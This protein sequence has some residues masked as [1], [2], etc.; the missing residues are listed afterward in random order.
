MKSVHFLVWVV[1]IFSGCQSA[2]KEEKE[3]ISFGDVS[4]PHDF[5][6]EDEVFG[7]STDNLYHEIDGLVKG[8]RIWDTGNP[9]K[10]P[11]EGDLSTEM[12]QLFTSK[13]FSINNP[14][15]LVWHT[16]GVLKFG[17]ESYGISINFVDSIIKCEKLEPIKGHANLRK[18]D[19][20]GNGVFVGQIE[21]LKKELPCF[22]RILKYYYRSS[23][24]NI[25]DRQYKFVH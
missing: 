25:G 1:V 8:D 2:L 13:S 5:G 10:V 12:Q 15:F 22:Y 18:S 9:K 7:E 16:Y 3:Y 21:Y 20:T 6:L 24:V 17:D 14:I 4:L 23:E 19:P 11:F